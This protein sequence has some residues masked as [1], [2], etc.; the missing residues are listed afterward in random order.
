[1]HV[2]AFENKLVLTEVVAGLV[3]VLAASLVSLD[4]FLGERPQTVPEVRQSVAVLAR[5]VEGLDVV[6]ELFVPEVLAVVVV[7]SL[8]DATCCTTCRCL[9]KRFRTFRG[10]KVTLVLRY[11]RV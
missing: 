2:Q 9:S 3:L 10:V 5:P 1:L 4:L 6:L 8:L 11:A 7:Y